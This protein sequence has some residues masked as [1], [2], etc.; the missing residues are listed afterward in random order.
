M[1]RKLKI[2]TKVLLYCGDENNSKT[3]P[4]FLL[5][6]SRKYDKCKAEILHINSVYILNFF[7]LLKFFF[8]IYICMKN[9]G[10]IFPV[11]TLLH[12]SRYQGRRIFRCLGGRKEN[13]V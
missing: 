8:T 13:L 3:Y 2:G 11:V 9:G 6:H 1:S 10:V 5:L 7:L 4:T 12:N